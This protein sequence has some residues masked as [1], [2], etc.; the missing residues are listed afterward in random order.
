MDEA[1]SIALTRRPDPIR[2]EEPA[3]TPPATPVGGDASAGIIAH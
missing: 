1:L 3:D 2:W